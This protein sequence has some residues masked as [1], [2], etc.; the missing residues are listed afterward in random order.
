MARHAKQIKTKVAPRPV[1]KSRWSFFAEAFGELKKA[2]WPTR[3]ETLRLSIL[4][5]VICLIVAVILG[6]VDYGFS[7]LISSLFPAR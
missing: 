7:R 1:K 5:I 2:H 4:V 3:E 6:A